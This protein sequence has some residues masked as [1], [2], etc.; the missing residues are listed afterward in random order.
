[1]SD[2]KLK[3]TQSQVWRFNLLG[4][5][6]SYSFYMVIKDSNSTLKKQVWDKTVECV[7]HYSWEKEDKYDFDS[8]I[9]RYSLYE[10]IERCSQYAKRVWSSTD[11]KS[12]ILY[13]LEVLNENY[14]ELVDWMKNRE[15]ELLKMELEKLESRTVDELDELLE[16]QKSLNPTEVTSPMEQNG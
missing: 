14:K 15:I 8:A 9:D 10:V 13:F 7:I 11:H 4:D 6:E 5:D 2:L 12:N 1:M 16:L 3:V